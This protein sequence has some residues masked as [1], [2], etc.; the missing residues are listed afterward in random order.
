M[1]NSDIC[2]MSLVDAAEAVRVKKL[3]PVE[4]VDAVLRRIEELNPKVNAYCTVASEA[5][6]RQAIDA[7]H[8]VMSGRKL[9][10]LHGVPISVKDLTFTAGIRTTAGSRVYENFVPQQDSVAVSRLKAAGAIIIGK[11][12]TPEFGWAAVTDNPLFGPT[13]NPWNLNLTSGGSSGGAAAA[14]A[15]GMGPL[16]IGS[17]GGGSIRI[18]SSFCGVFGLAPSFG[19]V[20][21]GPGFP[22]WETLSRTGPIT[23]TVK[24][25]ALAMEVI[26]G[27]DDRDAFSLPDTGLRIL[28]FLD[29]NVKKLRVAWSKDLGYA[30]VDRRVLAV[31]QAAV[32]AFDRLSS[33]VEEVA[34]LAVPNPET[35]FSKVV[36]VN[37]AAFLGDKLDR[38]RDRM[39]PSLVRFAEAHMDMAATEYISARLEMSRYWDG[40]Q[41][42]FEKYDLLLTPTVAVPPF[43][44]GRYRVLKMDG[45]EVSPLNWMAFTYPFNITGQPAASVPCG[46]TDAGLPVGLQLVGRRFEDLTVLKAAFA[47][48]QASPW[49]DTIPPVIAQM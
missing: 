44:I 13:R 40:I 26:G 32:R 45:T 9:G 7:E 33:G 34:D 27:R 19:R 35:A 2:L 42:L 8:A 21:Q 24:D 29:G 6:R 38:W 47:L 37:L 41:P 1:S 23:R 5:T 28:P 20:P 10:P 25:A 3:S 18:P 4:L 17:D 14:I 11:T 16:A 12:N 39:D 46:W 43:E 48:E 36:G 15:T 49:A 30:T 22:A 31:T